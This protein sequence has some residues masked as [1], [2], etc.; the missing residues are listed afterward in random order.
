MFFDFVQFLFPPVVKICRTNQ[1]AVLPQLKRDI[2]I[3]RQSS[4]LW[5]SAL[6]LTNY[7]YGYSIFFL[8]L[9]A[10]SLWNGNKPL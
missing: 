9:P 8:R 6:R 3:Q 1:I 7:L 10:G 4:R 2:Y 5:L